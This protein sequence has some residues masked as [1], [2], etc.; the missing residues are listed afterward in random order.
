MTAKEAA[1]GIRLELAVHNIVQRAAACVDAACSCGTV[2]ADADV[3]GSEAWRAACVSAAA[4]PSLR[5][6][7]TQHC[8]ASFA[9]VAAQEKAGPAAFGSMQRLIAGCHFAQHPPLV[10]LLAQ[11]AP[12]FQRAFIEY[13]GTVVAALVQGLPSSAVAPVLRT[14]RSKRNRNRS[15]RNAATVTAAAAAAVAT[16]A[17]ATAAG[18]PSATPTGSSAATP[19]AKQAQRKL[20]ETDA[21]APVVR[22]PESSRAQAALR[23]QAFAR[24]ILGRTR[25]READAARRIGR[26]LREHSRGYRLKLRRVDLE[27]A[28]IRHGPN[29]DAGGC[30]EPDSLT[31]Q[32]A[33]QAPLGAPVPYEMEYKAQRVGVGD[34]P[35]LAGALQALGGSVVFVPQTLNIAQRPRDYGV[36]FGVRP[37]DVLFP[38]CPDG[39]NRSQVMYQVLTAVKRA[40]GSRDPSSTVML[41]HGAVNGFD[42]YVRHSNVTNDNFFQFIHSK[43][44]PTD[45]QQQHLC[46][47][48]EAALGGA[49]TPRFG[50]DVLGADAELNPLTFDEEQWVR[51]ERVRSCLRQHFDR[52]YWARGARSGRLLF[53]CFGTAALVAL[54]R[55]VEVAR[56]TGQ[57][58]HGVHV[59]ALPWSDPV[60]RAL[61]QEAAAAAASGASGSM[62]TLRC[63]KRMFEECA[64]L[65]FCDAGSETAV[66]GH[67]SLEAGCGAARAQI[68]LGGGGGEAQ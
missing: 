28:C 44:V 63:F 52:A 51:L 56:Q 55:L 17:T 29:L 16:A 33:A 25:A 8:I 2:G 10:A 39:E 14:N 34:L 53:V 24:K 48:F 9:E 1:T 36:S 67:H 15:K 57:T 37:T 11:H 40:M 35:T 26:F 13:H 27:S 59:I 46:S 61:T 65:F 20:D 30:V 41:P 22:P 60:P 62:A 32:S 19:I 50:E 43:L 4:T 21:T 12:E 47:R 7:V 38:M 54:A 23:L 45:P 31:L 49:K 64:K 6:L 68:P 5:H 58:C 18:T 3:V 42:P 66:P